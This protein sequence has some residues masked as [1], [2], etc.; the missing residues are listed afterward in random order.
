MNRLQTYLLF[1]KFQRISTEFCKRFT[2]TIVF[3]LVFERELTDIG[4]SCRVQLCQK[5]RRTHLRK[6]KNSIPKDRVFKRLE[7]AERP[8]TPLSPL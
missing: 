7:S 1:V 5:R 2:N 6:Q 4:N 3:F 8:A